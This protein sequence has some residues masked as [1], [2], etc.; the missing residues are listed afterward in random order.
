[1]NMHKGI[2]LYKDVE[3]T[4]CLKILSYAAY[5]Y[6]SNRVTYNTPLRPCT[7]NEGLLK[8]ISFSYQNDKFDTTNYLYEFNDNVMSSG[9]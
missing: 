6:G 7:Y 8:T 4:I 3:N 2:N 1:M 5:M 9:R